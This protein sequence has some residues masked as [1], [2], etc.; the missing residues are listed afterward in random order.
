MPDYMSLFSLAAVVFVS[1]AI[2]W[3][4]VL[5]FDPEGRKFRDSRKR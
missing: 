2:I 5:S 3:F 4:V 1:V